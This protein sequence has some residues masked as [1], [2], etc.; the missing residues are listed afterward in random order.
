MKCWCSTTG[1]KCSECEKLDE[2]KLIKPKN[3]IKLLAYSKLL[4][5]DSLNLKSKSHYELSKY[6]LDNDLCVSQ[7]PDIELGYGKKGI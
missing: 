4:T 3:K 6:I 1:Y 2:W 5:S 7:I